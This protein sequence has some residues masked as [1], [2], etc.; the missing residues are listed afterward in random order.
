MCVEEEQEGTRYVNQL[1]DRE[2]E[3]PIFYGFPL[4]VLSP[5]YCGERKISQTFNLEMLIFSSYIYKF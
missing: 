3:T 4:C 1:F 5:C 2:V